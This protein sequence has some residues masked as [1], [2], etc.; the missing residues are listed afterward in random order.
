MPW[1][2]QTSDYSSSKA[3]QALWA[4]KTP[5]L[6]EL[7]RDISPLVKDAFKKRNTLVY[8]YWAVHE[9]RYPDALI[10]ISPDGGL[11]AYEASDFNQAIDVIVQASCA[12]QKFEDTV[13]K[14]LRWKKRPP[15]NLLSFWEKRWGCFLAY[16]L[17]ANSMRLGYR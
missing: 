10:K 4:I 15:L 8:A 7:K 13:R 16:H 14:H 6:R 2:A 1:R 5:L 17:Y 11:L 9:D 3:L 12:I